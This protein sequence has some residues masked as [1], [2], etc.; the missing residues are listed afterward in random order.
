MIKTITFQEAECMK[1]AGLSEATIL[2]YSQLFLT[3]EGKG[4]FRGTSSELLAASLKC[5]LQ[6]DDKNC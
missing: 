3:P 1:E 6:A 5:D 4:S 2:E